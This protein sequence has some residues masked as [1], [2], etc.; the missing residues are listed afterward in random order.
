MNS[1]QIDKE[2]ELPDANRDPVSGTPGS[3]PVGTGIG[4][5]VAGVA[6]V[7]A[8]GTLAAGPVGTVVGTAV[9][10]VAGGLAGKAIAEALDPTEVDDY[11]VTR[12]Q[13]ESYH[14]PEM[15]FDDYR[16]GYR[17]GADARRRYKDRSFEDVEQELAHEYEA[18]RGQSRLPW[19][20]A[21]DAARAAWDIDYRAPYIGA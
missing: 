1:K 7:A 14:D 8:A 2:P 10:V 5:A 16:P 17:L 4:A 13:G 9:G 6:T 11:W 19:D 15:S 18:A 12:Y 3:H 20:R 21:R